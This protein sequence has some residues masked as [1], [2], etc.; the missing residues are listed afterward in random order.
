MF[1]LKYHLVPLINS[2]IQNELSKE[3]MSLL[4]MSRIAMIPKVKEGT[5]TGHRAI[6]IGECIYRLVAKW[7]SFKM[8]DKILDIVQ[9]DQYGIKIKGGPEIL[10]H[11]FQCFF[12]EN[13]N[14]NLCAL[15]FDI[16]NGFGSVF[17]SPIYDILRRK[18]PELCNIFL[19]TYKE[20]SKLI[21]W[22]GDQVGSCKA[23][24]KQGDPLSMIYFCLVMEEA[25]SKIEKR[26]REMQTDDD[27]KIIKM[28]YADDFTLFGNPSFLIENFNIIVEEFAKVGLEVQPSKM[29][30]LLTKNSITPVEL[31]QLKSLAVSK[32]LVCISK[33]KVI[34]SDGIEI[35][36]EV[37]KCII[38]K[39]G[40]IIMGCPVGTD[41]YILK[42]LDR[43][44]KEFDEECSALENLI[45]PVDSTYK[46]LHPQVALALL[47]KCLNTKLIYDLRTIEP[48]LLESFTDHVDKKMD[49][50][51]AKIIQLNSIDQT[52]MIIRGL[53]YKFGGLGCQR[54][55][56]HV[57]KTQYALSLFNVFLHCSK[58]HERPNPM[59]R[60]FRQKYQRCFDPTDDMR[61]CFSIEHFS[62]DSD[63]QVDNGILSDHYQYWVAKNRSGFKPL[64]DS[65]H[66]LDE[67]NEGET[68]EVLI[69]KSISRQELIMKQAWSKAW[70]DLSTDQQG[71]IL[72]MRF[73]NPTQVPDSLHTEAMFDKLLKKHVMFCAYNNSNDEVNRMKGLN[74]LALLSKQARSTIQWRGGKWNHIKMAG[75][76]KHTLRQWLGITDIYYVASDSHSLACVGCNYSF[77][78]EDLILHEQ[79]C[80]RVVGKN[81]RYWRHDQVEDVLL[82]ICKEVGFQVENQ[83]LYGHGVMPNSD[84]QGSEKSSIADSESE[85]VNEHG[86]ES[87]M[88]DDSE[89]NSA[90][91]NT[92]TGSVSNPTQTSDSKEVDKKVIKGG[93]DVDKRGRPK[94]PPGF[95]HADGKLTKN[96][97][98]VFF[99]VTSH[100]IAN[101]INIKESNRI[102]IIDDLDFG[103]NLRIDAKLKEQYNLEKLNGSRDSLDHLEVI[104]FDQNGY[105][106]SRSM[107]WLEKLT[108]R[109]TVNKFLNRISYTFAYALGA[110]CYAAELRR[111]VMIS[112]V[113]MKNYYQQQ[114]NK[115]WKVGKVRKAR[116]IHKL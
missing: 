7:I 43:I 17:K 113:S 47:T 62:Y 9:P 30:L 102:M 69:Q 41:F 15:L 14:E 58:N 111:L 116:K 71:K 115:L 36:N 53:S 78:K 74:I 73:G 52:S 56:G 86:R 31:E 24:T 5:I 114:L 26:L 66:I 75:V 39:E 112:D 18:C 12:D 45:C 83:P 79:R 51:L 33:E 46:A 76:F 77:E 37:K 70:G 35:E 20:E 2:V 42:E 28:M 27:F 25:T 95:V 8:N 98:S 3:S 108:D 91:N 21:N 54:I 13:R 101:D 92:Q 109:Y 82:K 110:V 99:D 107:K 63:V 84:S 97:K 4:N 68:D 59:F 67:V 65:I 90:V 57:S 61:S 34:G 11:L 60:Y 44:R 80:N 16:K 105:F 40:V 6:G 29:K 55:H 48:R 22:K 19:A 106:D 100:V 89:V 72:H 38:T 64:F 93:G 81:S 88:D 50:L 94:N 87:E 96:D 10:K 23:G 104:T 103:F 1:R 49:H 85:V 32:D